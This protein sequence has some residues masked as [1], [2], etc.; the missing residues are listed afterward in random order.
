MGSFSRII[1]KKLS[2]S[3]N[4]AQEEFCDHLSVGTF[5]TIK[6]WIF[7]VRF[8]GCG[9]LFDP[10]PNFQKTLKNKHQTLKQINK[11]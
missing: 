8:S 4:I 6:M 5:Q 7:Y 9:K 3:Q 1:K 2:S 11:K 10:L